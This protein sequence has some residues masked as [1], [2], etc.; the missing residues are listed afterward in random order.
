MAG[1]RAS[2][3][4]PDPDPLEEAT[5]LARS[6][7]RIEVLSALVERPT[8]RRELGAELD[9]SQP[10]LG[11]ILNDLSARSWV[12]YDGE[13]YTATAT[14]EL[15]EAGIT[16]LRERLATE[17]RLRDVVAYLP[18]ET[19]DFDLRHLGGATVTRPTATRPNAPVDRMLELLRETEE[20]RLLSYAFNGSK[21]DLLAERADEIRVRGV[22]T[23][24]AIDAVAADPVLRTR[25]R[26]L[27]D[28]ADVEIRVSAGGLPAAVEVTDYRTHLLCRDEEGV[29]RAAVDTDDET[30]RA[31]A[32][33]LHE[34]YWADA[35]PLSSADLD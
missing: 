33:R 19:F 15:V 25:L 5:F 2:M 32:E 23:E 17:A 20:A 3:S 24:D 16:D 14:G 31:W 21:L 7:N 10:T 6:E 18:T 1:D 8:T 26:T 27:L 34:R 29:V 12:T 22:F 9:A 28:A 13:R 11:R 30:V 35:S 4:D